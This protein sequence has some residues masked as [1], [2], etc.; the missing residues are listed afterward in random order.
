MYLGRFFLFFTIYCGIIVF[1]EMVKGAKKDIYD[2]N[3]ALKKNTSI[4]TRKALFFIII[5]FFIYTIGFHFILD[6]PGLVNRDFAI[7]SGKI[8][9]IEKIE[10]NKYNITIESDGELI[11]FENVFSENLSKGNYIEIGCPPNPLYMDIVVKNNNNVTDLYQKYYGSNLL[12]KICIGIYV[13]LNFIVQ[14]LQIQK[15]KNTDTTKNNYIYLFWKIGLYLFTVVL[16]I[17]LINIVNNLCMGI[18][19]AVLFSIYNLYYL[20]FFISHCRNSGD[21]VDTILR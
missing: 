11:H 3:D 10:D 16:T 15:V 14:F 8:Q 9:N 5:C 2:P 4:K 19:A 21:K 12:E 18:L 20:I 6:I 1:P 7:F 17:S 13:V